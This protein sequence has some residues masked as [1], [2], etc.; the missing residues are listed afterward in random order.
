VRRCTDRCGRGKWRKE[1]EKKKK[2][3]KKKIWYLL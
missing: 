3:K 1:Q 2:K